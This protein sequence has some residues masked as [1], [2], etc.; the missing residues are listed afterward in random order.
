[1]VHKG[2]KR[3]IQNCSFKTQKVINVNKLHTCCTSSLPPSWVIKVFMFL[4]ETHHRTNRDTIR[5]IPTHMGEIWQHTW[6]HPG[7]SSNPL[8]LCDE[9]A[10]PTFACIFNLAWFNELKDPW[11]MSPVY[12]LQ[13]G[14]PW[15]TSV[16]VMGI[17]RSSR[18]WSVWDSRY[19]HVYVEDRKRLRTS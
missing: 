10:C 1:M 7:R 18:N 4:E 9:H 14:E 19:V 13:C 3:I 5:L 15:S 17:G 12:Q 2:H 11:E 8:L 6:H 16:S